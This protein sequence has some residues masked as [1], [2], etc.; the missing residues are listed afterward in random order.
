MY[1]EINSFTKIGMIKDIRQYCQNKY[2]ITPGLRVSRD[3]ADD[4]FSTALS[5]VYS[6]LEK[7]IAAAKE[8]GMTYSQIEAK[9]SLSFD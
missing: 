8:H 9:V 3:L 5:D 2:G 1:Q 7:A 6:N 4:I